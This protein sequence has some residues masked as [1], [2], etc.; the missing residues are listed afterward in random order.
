ME[1]ILATRVHS[2][3]SIDTFI[4]CNADLR[5]ICEHLAESLTH[6][7]TVYA[8]DIEMRDIAIKREDEIDCVRFTAR[9]IPEVYTV[10]IR[11]IPGGDKVFDLPNARTGEDIRIAC[12]LVNDDSLSPYEVLT[13]QRVGWNET[14]RVWVYESTDDFFERR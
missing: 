14:R 11:K 4:S 12:L 8:V 2:V 9:W 7:L 3:V 10:E 1:R 5:V 6:M 13:C